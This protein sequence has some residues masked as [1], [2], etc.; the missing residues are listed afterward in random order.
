MLTSTFK[1]ILNLTGC[2]SSITG[3]HNES[4]SRCHVFCVTLQELRSNQT[5]FFLGGGRGLDIFVNIY[6]GYVS[7]TGIFY[8]REELIYFTGSML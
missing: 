3:S 2:F 5:F 1:V 6:F 4:N 7:C 8:V